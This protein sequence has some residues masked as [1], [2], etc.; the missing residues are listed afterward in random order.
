[1]KIRTESEME[2][3]IAKHQLLG[4]FVG[5]IVVMIVVALT[6]TSPSKKEDRSINR[7]CYDVCK[8]IASKDW[9]SNSAFLPRSKFLIKLRD[10]MEECRLENVE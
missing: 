5:V 9:E 2:E 3:A 6:I 10:C 8:T 4:L 7:T 1:M